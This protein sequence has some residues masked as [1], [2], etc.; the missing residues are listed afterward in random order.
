M[1]NID[2]LPE[3]YRQATKRRRTSY[4]RLV[5]TGMFVVA[6][7]GAAGGL[8][9]VERDVRKQW[10]HVNSLHAAAKAQQMLVATKQAEL[11][12]LR[13]KADLAT[14]LRHPWPRSRIV[15]EALI[16]LPQEVGIER[17]RIHTAERPKVKTGEVASSPSSETTKKAATAETD[18]N[19][20]RESVE[21]LDVLVTLEGITLDQPALHVYLQSLAAS[22]LFVKAELTSIE[23]STGDN[24]GGESKFA[25]KIVV[26]PGWG[27][28]GGPH[29]DETL[30][31]YETAANENFNA[32][33]ATGVGREE[34]REPVEVA[35]RSVP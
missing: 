4:W 8:F 15:H 25:V 7:A 13:H 28:T 6:F 29:P 27:M 20:L 24:T 2:F 23:A 33:P 22:K 10:E 26:R 1:K 5:V 21:A 17:I 32:S 11:A 18:L 34:L 19:E 12:D 3:R 9:F 30:A 14:F 31:A 35:E 16:G